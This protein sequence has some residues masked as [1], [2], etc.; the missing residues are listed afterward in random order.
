MKQ[1]N[2]HVCGSARNG[3]LIAFFAARLE[4]LEAIVQKPRATSGFLTGFP[5]PAGSDEEQ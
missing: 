2:R 4:V 1:T 5:A 3:A